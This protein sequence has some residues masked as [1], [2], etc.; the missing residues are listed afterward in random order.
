MV[1]LPVEQSQFRPAQALSPGAVLSRE[2]VSLPG[3]ASQ[4][5][6]RAVSSP[7]AALLPVVS[8]QEAV[9]LPAAA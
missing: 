4:E 9:S 2:V 8:S 3:V 7:E 6:S 5:L 1:L